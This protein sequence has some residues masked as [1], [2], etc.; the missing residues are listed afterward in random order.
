MIPALQ[1]DGHTVYGFEAELVDSTESLLSNVNLADALLLGF[2]GYESGRIWIQFTPGNPG[3]PEGIVADLDSWSIV[4][5]PL[6]AGFWLFGGALL[7]LGVSRGR[8]K[9][10]PG[11]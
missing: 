11:A 8:S 9:M 3:S 6:P 10:V 2:G 1:I 4:A 7:S 5:V